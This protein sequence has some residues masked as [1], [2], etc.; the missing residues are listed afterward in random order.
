MIGGPGASVAGVGELRDGGGRLRRGPQLASRWQLIQ[1]G[2]PAAADVLVTFV[3]MFESAS[4]LDGL[5]DEQRQA[6]AHPSGPLLVLAG[7][8]TGKTRTLVARAAWLC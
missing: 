1:R 3:V 8:G 6:A 7:A 2:D 4:A 5:N